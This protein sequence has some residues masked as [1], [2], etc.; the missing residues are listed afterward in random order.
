VYVNIIH[1]AR[2]QGIRRTP[3]YFMTVT[4][5]FSETE[6]A[7]IKTHRLKEVWAAVAPGVLN[8]PDDASL[9]TIGLFFIL[10][11]TILL[12]N[13]QYTLG[14]FSLLIGI[15]MVIIDK[16][17]TR[18]E[19]DSVSIKDLLSGPVIIRTHTPLSAR[20]A[21]ETI[22]VSLHSLKNYID[23]SESLVNNETFEL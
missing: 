21:H 17:L 19:R 18:S 2:R 22:R 5:K 12:F 20:E 16:F 7:I 9:R 1:S 14:I 23:G 10:T 8:F 11:G 6:R 3:V 15:T 13:Q 4:A